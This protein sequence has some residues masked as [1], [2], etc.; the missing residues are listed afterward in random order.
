MTIR[1][2]WR[3]HLPQ[4]VIFVLVSNIQNDLYIIQKQFLDVEAVETEQREAENKP[5]DREIISSAKDSRVDL[6]V[7][8]TEETEEGKTA[9]VSKTSE[10]TDDKKKANISAESHEEGVNSPAEL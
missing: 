7:S 8:D 5:Q 6:P 9:D 4:K 10:S 1:Q 3:M 2:L